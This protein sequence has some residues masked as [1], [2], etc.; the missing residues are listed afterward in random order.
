MTA[1]FPLC[2]VMMTLYRKD[3]ISLMELALNSIE[4]QDYEGEIRIF[5]CVDGPIPDAHATWLAANRMRFY[6]VVKNDENMGLAR[7]LNRL[8][9]LLDEE[10][11]VFRMDGDDISIPC[12]FRKQIELMEAHPE[13]DLIGCQAEDIDLNGE[14]LRKRQ[15]PVEPLQVRRALT[16]VTPIL[17]PAFCIR[18]TLLR[19]PDLRYPNAHLCEDAAFLVTC[20]GRGKILANHSETL[21]QWRQGEAFMQRRRDPKRGWAELTWYMTA[22]KDQGRMFSVEPLFPIMRFIMRLLPVWLVKIIYN[23]G[24]REKA[25]T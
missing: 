19:D 6:N 1:K 2:A 20:S 10:D 5:L 4:E 15:F 16:R 21:L 11:Y 3:S 14:V 8:I 24:L 12:R 13:F 7:S 25:I 22:V 9:D 23:S 17:H 18:R